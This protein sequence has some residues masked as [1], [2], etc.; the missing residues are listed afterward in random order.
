MSAPAYVL[1]M[2]DEVSTRNTSSISSDNVGGNHVSLDSSPLR[3]P[4]DSM[5]GEDHHQL[6]GERP[7]TIPLIMS[8][9]W[10]GHARQLSSKASSTTKRS[11]YRNGGAVRA[12]LRRRVVLK[13]GECNVVQSRVAQRRLRYLQDIFTTLVDTQWRWTLLVFALSF[14]LSWLGFALIWWLI[15]FT[16]GDLE[17]E[18]LPD[19][20]EQSNWTPCS[21]TGV[22]IQAFM[23]G[24]VFAKMSRPKQRA[25]TLLFSRSAVVCLR[26]G[27]LCL[28]FRV[29]D[30]RKSHIIGATVRAQ[31]IRTRTT[32][33]GEVLYQHQAELNVGTDVTRRMSNT[34]SSLYSAPASLIHVPA[35]VMSTPQQSPQSTPRLNKHLWHVA[36]DDTSSSHN[37]GHLTS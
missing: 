28:M 24:I 13:S 2:E 32:K 36:M 34:V 23:V 18:H 33:E 31:L 19:Q 20:Q 7:S 15:A 9:G 8:T 16:H 27:D 35:S 10:E 3:S 6:L 37:D 14:I 29:G 11:R 25:Q 26:D 22:M 4:V 12:K 1:G 17:P 30:M 21:I 5:I